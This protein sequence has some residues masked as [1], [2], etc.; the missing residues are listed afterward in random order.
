MKVWHFNSLLI[1]V[2]SLIFTGCSST[3]S[4]K[5][6]KLHTLQGALQDASVNCTDGEAR[7][8]AVNWAVQG[9]ADLNT[10][11][12][13]LERSSGEYKKNR[14]LLRNLSLLTSRRNQSVEILCQRIQQANQA[15]N[16][17]LSGDNTKLYAF[18]RDE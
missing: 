14:I 1:V 15:T 8:R 6:G 4:L 7:T 10:R 13:Y 5:Y 12:A 2:F 16:Q 18:A 17:Y 9:V 11:R 3:N